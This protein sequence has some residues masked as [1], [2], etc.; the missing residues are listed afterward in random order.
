M[1]ECVV[2]VSEGR[3]RAVIDRLGV[4]GAP[5]VLDV[6]SDS[7]HHRTVLTLCG[8]PAAELERAV[9]RLAA[10]A[11][12]LIDLRA[13]HGVHPRIGAVDVVPFVS[14]GRRGRSGQLG[15]GPLTPALAARDAFARWAADELAL[16]CFLYGPE[17]SLPEVRRG[18]WATLQ[19]DIGPREAHRT[20]GAVAV[21]ARPVLIAY[22]LW[23]CAGAD[24][25]TAR[26][27]ATAVRRP[28]LRTLGL[29][30]GE[31]LQISCNLTD[32]RRLGPGAAFDA[33]TA[34]LPTGTAIDHAELVGLM[35]RGVLQEEPA[36]RWTE[37]G[38]GPSVTIEARLEQAGLDGG[39]F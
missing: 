34:A 29:R 23:L 36:H 11:V 21:G 14:L 5:Y 16:P 6:H 32:P 8:E 4:A 30:V 27:A 22:N 24:L 31:R 9:R 17:R 1:L 19:P 28:G 2:N 18:A 39:S 12:G 3:D 13:H 10:T 38:I 20:A 25:A 7:H 33:V 37:L 35:P 26:R 15:E